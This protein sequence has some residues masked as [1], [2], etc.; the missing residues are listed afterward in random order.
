MVSSILETLHRITSWPKYF[1]GTLLVA[2][3]SAF[4]YFGLGPMLL[5]L[6]AVIIAIHANS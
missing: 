2:G 5:R 6:L 4:L 1:I 3:V